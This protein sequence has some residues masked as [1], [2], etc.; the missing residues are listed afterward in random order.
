MGCGDTGGLGEV[1]VGVI[2]PTRNMAATLGSALESA[3]AQRPDSVVVVDD[4]SE[5]DSPQIVAQYAARYPFIRSIRQPEKSPCHLEA[6]QSVLDSLDCDHLIGLGADDFLLPGLIDAVRENLDQA[7]VFSNY[8][9]E[10]I[11]QPELRWHAIHP[12]QKNTV[13]SPEEMRHRIRTQP[14]V[15]TGIGSSVSRDVLQW[16]SRHEWQR[17]GP[18]QDS[19]GYA[20]A[21]ATFGCVYVPIFGAHIRFNPEGYGQRQSETGRET[22]AKEAVSFL[23]RAGIDQETSAALIQKR[24]Y[25]EL[26]EQFWFNGN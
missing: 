1:S 11:S 13:L 24:C 22:W 3:C 7:V 6:L 15:E 14:A 26:C 25:Y 9:C 18:H 21:A 12:F 8:S 4:A 20:A 17:L 2:I 5:D 19:I 16:L 10:L 23:Q